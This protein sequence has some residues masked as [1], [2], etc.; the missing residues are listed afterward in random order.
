MIGTVAL[1]GV[2]VEPSSAPLMVPLTAVVE[3]HGDGSTYAVLV[4]E[5]LGDREVAR[6]RRVELGEVQGNAVAV[7]SG[8][9]L[10]D[11]VIV[12]GANLLNDGDH[13]R[14]IP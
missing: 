4:V 9:A 14:V 5:R 1:G 10:G 11:R 8:V 2:A 13:I 12:T 3:A 6:E 7:V